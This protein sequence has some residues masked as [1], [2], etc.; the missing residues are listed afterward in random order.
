MA[1]KT[2]YESNRLIPWRGFLL[3]QPVCLPKAPAGNYETTKD[4]QK[5]N[6]KRCWRH[7]TVKLG[8]AKWRK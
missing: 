2:H 6:C 3:Y 4:P 7:L 5:V 1:T 8:T